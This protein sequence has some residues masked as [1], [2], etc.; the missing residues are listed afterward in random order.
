MRTLLLFLLIALLAGSPTEGDS[1]DQI[2]PFLNS[3]PR[4]GER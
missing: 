1:T 2:L 3:L 4:G